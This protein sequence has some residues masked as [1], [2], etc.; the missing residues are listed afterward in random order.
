MYIA[1]NRWTYL[2]ICSVKEI[3][4]AFQLMR[5][6]TRM[7]LALLK[8]MIIVRITFRIKMLNIT[9]NLA[10]GAIIHYLMLSTKYN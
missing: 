1:T 5:C 4:R 6:E 8:Y 9:H 3:E 10:Q 7:K 2:K